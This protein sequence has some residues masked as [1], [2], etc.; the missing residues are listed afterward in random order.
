M[1]RKKQT[2]P[3]A[4]VSVGVALLASVVIAPRAFP[5][6]KSAVNAGNPSTIEDFKAG[7]DNRD[8]YQRA[9]ELLKVLGVASGDW[10]ADV[11]AGAGYY[12]MRLSAMVGPRGKVFAEDISDASMRWLAT[13]VKV[14]DLLN[15]EIVKGDV[16]DPK[17]PS[18]KLA[19]ILVVDSYHH[20]ERVEPVLDRMLHALEPGRRLVI[21]D[22]SLREHRDRARADQLKTHEI[23]PEVVRAEIERA[24]FQFVSCDEQ[25]V[26]QDPASK[27]PRAAEA[28]LWVMV[29]VRPK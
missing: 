22:Y 16:D 29:A 6:Q 19:A 9:T 5:Q 15:V 14:F 1:M 18:D 24:G 11:G 3:S 26:K 10:V 20:F 12:A 8:P 28:D 4:L 2:R 17:L 25:Y 21:A 7:D 13:R 27:Y 23:A